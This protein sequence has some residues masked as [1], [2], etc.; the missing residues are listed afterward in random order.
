MSVD[1]EHKHVAFRTREKF[2]FG[3]C[4]FCSGC[5]H[6]IRLKR[7]TR[8]KRLVGPDVCHFVLLICDIIDALQPNLFR[9]FLPVFRQRC[10][11]VF[12]Y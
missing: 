6:K 4:V 12:A 8:I 1:F 2:K 11:S 3:V 5:P 10:R 7:H 9:A